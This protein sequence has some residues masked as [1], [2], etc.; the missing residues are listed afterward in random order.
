MFL[1][2]NAVLNYFASCKNKINVTYRRQFL[3]AKL[4]A[5]LQGHFL[6]RISK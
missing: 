2:F 4:A 3:A 6:L 5:T 1:Q